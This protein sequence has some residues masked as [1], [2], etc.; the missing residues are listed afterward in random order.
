MLVQITNTC[1]MGCPHC[2]Q[3]STPHP[4]HMTWEHVLRARWFAHKSGC[5][6]VLISG[7][8]PTEHP[9]FKE[10]V[11]LFLEFKYVMIASN[12]QWQSDERKVSEISYLL[13]KHKNLMM[14]I[15]SNPKI[16]PHQVDLKWFKKF[17]N[18]TVHTGEIHMKAL[19]RAANNKE[20][21]RMAAED[22]STMS[23]LSSIAI[24]AQVP[25]LQAIGIMELRGMFCHPL[26][27]FQGNLHWS[28]S[29]L[30]PAFGN[31]DE[32]FDDLALKA[33]KW[34]PC[35]KCAD[36]QKLVRKKEINYLQI[37]KILKI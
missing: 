14:Q 11:E 16:Y 13:R 36:Y 4:Q 12:G 37:R 24:S 6:V 23:C 18:V 35:C 25:Y 26:V 21:S 2:L 5:S 3:N 15:T 22:S 19:G 9:R 32:E 30:C 1:N 29:W 7:G 27:D 31:I 17:P 10:I 28:E 34:R 20:F 8:E 33:G